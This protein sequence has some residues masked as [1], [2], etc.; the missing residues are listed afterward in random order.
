MHDYSCNSQ[1][2]SSQCVVSAAATSGRIRSFVKRYHSRRR[3]S[4][5]GAESG[6]CLAGCNTGAT[7]ID[8]ALHQESGAVRLRVTDDGRGF[9]V[10]AMLSSDTGHYGL[11]GMQER[12]AH[13]R[14]SARQELDER[15]AGGGD[16]PG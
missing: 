16:R 9:D 6:H 14:S 10:H 3:M 11:T 8:V 12:G 4:V 15:N 5:S 13:R 7:R 2:L 1:I